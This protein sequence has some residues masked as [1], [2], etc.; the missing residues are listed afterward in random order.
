LI[1]DLCSDPA[2][3]PHHKIALPINCLPDEE[4]HETNMH[5]NYVK[6]II[7]TYYVAHN[8]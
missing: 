1:G 4:W 7:A 3:P 2:V 6:F 8:V 5:L